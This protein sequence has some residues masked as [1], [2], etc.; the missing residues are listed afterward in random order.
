MVSV[1]AMTI[2]FHISLHAVKWV[3]SSFWFIGGTLTGT[4]TPGQNE[5]GSNVNKGIIHMAQSSR[6]GASPS[7]AL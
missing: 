6:T 5:P 3:N 2:Q 7:D 1:I 4:I